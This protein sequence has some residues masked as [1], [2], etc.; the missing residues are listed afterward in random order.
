MKNFCPV[1]IIIGL[2]YCLYIVTTPALA[3]CNDTW[4]AYTACINNT[5]NDCTEEC[6]HTSILDELHSCDFYNG[7]WCLDDHDCCCPDE[8]RAHYLCILPDE[9]VAC[10]DADADAA[11]SSSG[12]RGYQ[13][14]VLSMMMVESSV[15]MISVMLLLGG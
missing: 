6:T 3:L 5:T 4:N 2:C 15:L 1:P 8:G 9:C 7:I 11:T 10:A 12:C 14:N 13:W